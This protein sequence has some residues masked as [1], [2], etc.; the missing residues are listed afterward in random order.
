MARQAVKWVP[1]TRLNDRIAEKAAPSFRD[2][3]QNSL[4]G[5]PS[6][7]KVAPQDRKWVPK[8]IPNDGRAE[9][10]VPSYHDRSRKG[11]QG[12]P[13]VAKM[14]SKALIMEVRATYDDK[15]SETASLALKA[16]CGARRDAK[17]RILKKLSIPKLLRD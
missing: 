16:K 17:K 1:K 12:Y 9:K 10:A 3:C 14:V 6:R 5:A 8:M 13:K 11:A 15:D 7:P 2:Q 4:R